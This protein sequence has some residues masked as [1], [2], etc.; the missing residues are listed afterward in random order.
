M[1]LKAKI[2]AVEEQMRAKLAE[3]RATLRHAG[4]KGQQVEEEI[5]SFL[6]E[7]LP[8]RL[9]VG[10]GEIIDTSGARSSE[11]D[12]IIVTDDHPFTFARDLP[13]LFFVEGVCGVG[14]VKAVLGPDELADTLMRRRRCV[15]G[16]ARRINGFQR[17]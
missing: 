7:Y 6:R 11:T 1:T 14:E 2:A 17:R 9:E 5:R 13:G 12:V 4:G 3:I 8:R 16:C 10:H 15:W